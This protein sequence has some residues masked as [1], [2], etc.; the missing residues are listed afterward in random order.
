M[1]LTTVILAPGASEVGLGAAALAPLCVDTR[2]PGL[3]ALNSARSLFMH[4]H[5]KWS[6][7][8]RKRTSILTQSH[9]KL[10]LGAQ[11]APK[12]PPGYIYIHAK[13]EIHYKSA[14]HES[15]RRATTVILHEIA[16]QDLVVTEKV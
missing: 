2:L 16:F 10:H 12:G 6:P 5:R 8:S 13:S 9:P 1:C 15:W 4:R 11:G 3:P 14:R 7:F